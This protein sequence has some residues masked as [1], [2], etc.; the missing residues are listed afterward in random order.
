MKRFK[1]RLESGSPVLGTSI[2]FEAPGLIESLSGQDWDWFWL[3]GQHALRQHTWLEHIRA[4]E[5]IDIPPV[6]RVPSCDGHFIS[7]ALDLG[8]WD[9]MVPMVESAE[10]AR[11]AVQAAYF[12]P[13]GSRSAAGTRPI[14]LNGMEYLKMAARWTSLTVQI[15]TKE[16]MDHLHEIAAVPGVDSIFIGTWDLCLS[17]GIPLA[18]KDTS[19]EIEDAIQRVGR[20]AADNG[21]YAGIIC[22]PEAI[23]MR[24]EQGYLFFILSISVNLISEP[25]SQLLA[26]TRT[27]LSKD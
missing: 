1:E 14:V 3:D 19:K 24:M 22:A 20:V 7:Q 26:R 25:M 6:I 13:L 9:I 17:M 2:L 18:E 10:Q 8:A 12:P 21:K 15:E 11:E 16:G 5:L 23:P 27:L 4:C